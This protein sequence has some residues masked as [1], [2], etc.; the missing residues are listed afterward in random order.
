LSNDVPSPADI[1]NTAELV[2]C[3][4]DREKATLFVVG[5]HAAVRS[6]SILLDAQVILHV[7]VRSNRS[8]LM[9]IGEQLDYIDKQMEIVSTE[10]NARDQLYSIKKNVSLPSRNIIRANPFI[11]VW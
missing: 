2:A 7:V 5:T 11:T 6:S 3:R 10:R 8:M 9:F 4:L 1:K